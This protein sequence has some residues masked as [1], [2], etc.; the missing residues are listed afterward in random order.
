[1]LCSFD[2]GCM[3]LEAGSCSWLEATKCFSD[4]SQMHSMLLQQGLS[5]LYLEWQLLTRMQTEC[6]SM[7]S[8]RHIRDHL[9]PIG[10]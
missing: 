9:P 3:L 6:V 8:G 5:R 2:W 1:M 7:S 4:V 10:P